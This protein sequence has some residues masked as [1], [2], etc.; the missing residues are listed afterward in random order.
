VKRTPRKYA[1][2][3]NPCAKCQSFRH[4][5]CRPLL[6]GTLCTCTCKKAC[7][8]RS[9]KDTL[10]AERQ[11]QGLPLLTVPELNKLM[12]RRGPYNV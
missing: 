10:D 2:G 5:C 8:T 11:S 12:N 4:Y 6:A 9:L 1:R 3:L 7:K